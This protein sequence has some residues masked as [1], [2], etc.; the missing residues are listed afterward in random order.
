VVSVAFAPDGK[1]VAVSA[2][3]V[4]E[5]VN[6]LWDLASE[7]NTATFKADSTDDLPVVHVAFSPDGKTLA[8]TSKDGIKLWDVPAAK[9]T[10]KPIVT[11]FGVRAKCERASRRRGERKSHDP[12]LRN[13]ALCGGESWLPVV[14]PSACRSARTTTWL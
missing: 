14:L 7:K 1:T 10:K 4:K 12:P 5:Y 8:L 3:D 6:K 2:A 13:P 11:E 9:K